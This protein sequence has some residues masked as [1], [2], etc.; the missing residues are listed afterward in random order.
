MI[1]HKFYFVLFC[2]IACIL[3]LPACK[4]TY[5]SAYQANKSKIAINLKEHNLG[6]MYPQDTLSSLFN[7]ANLDKFDY[8]FLNNTYY[9]IYRVGFSD[10]DYGSM[11]NVVLK[12]CVIDFKILPGS[13]KPFN[14]DTLLINYL[15]AGL[16]CNKDKDKK[17]FYSYAEIPENYQAI[18]LKDPY[19][20]PE[21][22][23]KNKWTVSKNSAYMHE[24]F[25]E[26]TFVTLASKLAYN[27]VDK[28]DTIA[29]SDFHNGHPEIASKVVITRHVNITVLVIAVVVIF[30]VLLQL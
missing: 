22:F 3:T 15:Q 21:G 18:V 30:I 19:N 7:A 9:Q 6:Y 5:Q 25:N 2:L 16:I 28:I 20:L 29:L 27:S 13:A 17:L 14:G 1:N 8:T 11:G 4:V 12:D 26:E 24:G 10:N 23:P